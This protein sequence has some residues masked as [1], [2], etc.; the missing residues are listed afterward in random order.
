MTFT[1]S[2]IA[3][4]RDRVRFHLGDTDASAPKFSDEEI[5]GVLVECDGKYKQAVLACI[6]NLVARLSQPDF[7]ADWLQ[8]TSGDAI[9]SWRTLYSEKAGEFGLAAGRSFT[10]GVTNVTRS[11]WKTETDE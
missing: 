7:K 3:T 1:Y 8:V 10:S 5:D 9:A 4:D 6:R 11:D 2:P